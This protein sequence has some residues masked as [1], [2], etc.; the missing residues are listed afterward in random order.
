MNKTILDKLNE[1]G[2]EVI[3]VAT[4]AEASAKVLELI[5]EN[6]EIMTMSSTTLD[7]LGLTE[8]LNDSEKYN[9]IRAKLYSGDPEARYHASL[10]EYVVGS[11]QAI[12]ENGELIFASATGSQL[13]AYAYGAKNVIFVV[14]SQKIVTNI[15]AGFKRIKDEIFPLEDARALK[16]YGV[17]TSINKLLI[18]NKEPVANRTTII[19]VDQPLGF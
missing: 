16:A 4:G 6:S 12:T 5:P 15:D 19:F 14:G 8:K 3:T 13:P 1:N 2:F 7:T 10:P 9:P 11:P 18:I 17:H